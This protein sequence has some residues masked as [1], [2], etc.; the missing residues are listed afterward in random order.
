LI[1]IS[2][3]SI[4]IILRDA[5]LIRRWI[6]KDIRS[7][8]ANQIAWKHYPPPRYMLNKYSICFCPW[9]S[10][11]K[12]HSMSSKILLALGVVLAISALGKKIY[13]FSVVSKLTTSFQITAYIFHRGVGTGGTRPPKFCQV[14]FFREQS[15]L[16]WDDHLPKLMALNW[17]IKIQKILYFVIPVLVFSNLVPRLFPHVK[18]T[19]MWPT[20]NRLPNARSDY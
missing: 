3:I 1:F 15:A 14:P 16:F 5:K 10:F 8:A 18:E 7:W 13:K 19:L 9:F 12:D 17:L 20:K 6:V 11:G 4:Q 2:T